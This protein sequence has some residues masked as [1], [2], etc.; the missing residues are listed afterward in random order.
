MEDKL[1]VAQMLDCLRGIKHTLRVKSR[2]VQFKKQNIRGQ[3]EGV[4]SRTLI[5]RIHQKAHKGA[6]EY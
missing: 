5:D 6:V 4:R 2:M 3:R 1:R